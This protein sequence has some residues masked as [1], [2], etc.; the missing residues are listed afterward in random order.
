MQSARVMVSEIGVE[1]EGK[2]RAMA[3][4]GRANLV[5]KQPR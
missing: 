3:R 5:H 4:N 2:A 1:S